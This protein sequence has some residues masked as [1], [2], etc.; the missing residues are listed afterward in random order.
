MREEGI[1]IKASGDLCEVSVRRKT[2]CGENC[3]SCKA[4]CGAREQICVAKNILGAV[5]GDRVVIEMDSQKVLKS[6]F[7]VYI[8]PVLVFLVI[9]AIISENGGSQLVSALCSVVAAIVVFVWLRFYDKKHKKD[10]IPKV[11]EIL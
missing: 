6:A 11:T 10:F 1:V 8:L 3:A 2:A 9:F 7:L 5:V 4:T